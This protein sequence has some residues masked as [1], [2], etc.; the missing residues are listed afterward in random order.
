MTDLPHRALKE[1]LQFLPTGGG[2]SC[3]LVHLEFTCVQLKHAVLGHGPLLYP[4][5]IRLVHKKC[6]ED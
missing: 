5:A 4:W 3:L 1:G 6:V 2:K